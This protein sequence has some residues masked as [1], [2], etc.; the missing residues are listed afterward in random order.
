MTTTHHH[1]EGLVMKQPIR[2]TEGVT[3]RSRPKARIR[4]AA[5]RGERADWRADVRSELGAR[6]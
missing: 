4:R 1:T 2:T 3:I 6:R 5:K